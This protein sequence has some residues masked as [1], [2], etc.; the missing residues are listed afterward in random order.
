MQ[1]SISGVLRLARIRASRSASLWLAIAMRGRSAPSN[2]ATQLLLHFVAAL[3]AV[4]VKRR[5]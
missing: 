1:A 3:G 4:P 5:A 2:N